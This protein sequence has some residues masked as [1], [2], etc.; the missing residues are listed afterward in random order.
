MNAAV[1][2]FNKTIFGEDA[3]QFNPS[4]WLRGEDSTNM[5]RYMFQFGGG[6]RTCIGKN[7]RI[8]FRISAPS[9]YT[10]RLTLLYVSD[11]ALRNLQGGTTDPSKL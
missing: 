5:E 8:H 9:I 10:A 6:S 2:H 1:I 7:V 3:D 4:R 11:L